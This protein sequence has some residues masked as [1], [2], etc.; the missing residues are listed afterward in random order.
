MTRYTL[1]DHKGFDLNPAGGR[2]VGT[3]GFGMS[4]YLDQGITADVE[5]APKAHL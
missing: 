5:S 1:L 4:E 2:V 3:T